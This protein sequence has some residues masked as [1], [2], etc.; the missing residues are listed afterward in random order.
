LRTFE[1]NSPLFNENVRNVWPAYIA[2]AADFLFSGSLLSTFSWVN[3]QGRQTARTM[4]VRSSGPLTEP[5]ARTN[6]PQA[7][8]LPGTIAPSG[9]IETSSVQKTAWQLGKRLPHP[10][11]QAKDT[12]GCFRVSRAFTRF[13]LR[14]RRVP[15]SPIAAAS[16]VGGHIC[17]SLKQPLF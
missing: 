6:E 1:A 8:K 9:R 13:L 4:A 10:K 14:K 7:P 16:L 5:L 12:G 3:G 17:P 11:K 2:F 15:A